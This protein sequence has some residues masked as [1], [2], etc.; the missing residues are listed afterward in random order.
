VVP[1]L[2][3][4]PGEAI[5]L[6]MTATGAGSTTLS[7]SAWKASGPA[8]A[9]PQVTATDSTAALQAAGSVGLWTYLTGSATNAPVTVTVDDLLV[10]ATATP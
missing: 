5:T 6:R 10:Q 1:G 3:A 8:P 7:A 4:A 2:T 9:A